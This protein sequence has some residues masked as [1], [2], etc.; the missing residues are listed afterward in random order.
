MVNAVGYDASVAAGNP[1]QTALYQNISVMHS[2][3]ERW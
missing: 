3:R 2:Y 1:T